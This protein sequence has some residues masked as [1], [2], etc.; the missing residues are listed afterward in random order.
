[1][2]A[3]ASDLARVY[4]LGGDEVVAVFAACGDPLSVGGLLDAMLARLAEPF[5]I[6][7]Q[8][9]FISASAG[10]AFAPADGSNVDELIAN[11]DLALYEAKGQ[12]GRTYRLFLPAYRAR[13]EARR[14]LDSEL[15]RAVSEREFELFFQP[16]VRLRDS[17]IL[18]AEALVRWRHPT[19]GLLGPEAFIDALVESP[20][21]RDVGS[22]IL[23]AAC[24]NSAAWR[25]R[26]LT[27]IRIGV[28]LFPA[29]FH[30]DGLLTDIENVLSQ[31][32]LPA[33]S[34][35]LEITEN[36][37]LNDDGKV[38]A[39]LTALREMGVHLAFDD[40]GTGYASLNYL[41]RYP[42]SRIK[43]D[44][45]FVR[46][47]PESRQDAAIVRSIIVMAHN[48]GLEVVAEGV[49]TPEQAAFLQEEGCDQ[50]QGF[51]FARPLS[52][53]AFEEL[54]TSWQIID[55]VGESWP[56]HRRA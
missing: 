26:G 42:L 43:I 13:A 33:D 16:Q 11:A 14:M 25:T 49:E 9:L 45:S 21:V 4:R 30:H 55:S 56:L 41:T 17:A 38:L 44:Q 34:L 18:G 27:P 22:W 3:T 46:K 36:I 37:G 15:R 7:G 24:S 5:E 53:G 2:T 52:N 6:G 48:L 20:T 29:Q 40:F 51:L 39:R 19:R 10:I 12:G 54:L 35:E 32:G 28:N 31:T 8:T 1:M 50:V 23:Q 47:I